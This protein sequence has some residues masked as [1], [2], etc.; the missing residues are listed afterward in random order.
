MRKRFVSDAFSMI[1]NGGV[2]GKD[3]EPG[4]WRYKK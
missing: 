1:K 2:P 3:Y 4:A